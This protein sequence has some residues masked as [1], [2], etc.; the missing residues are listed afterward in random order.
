MVFH[1]R[2]QDWENLLFLQMPNCQQEI[3]RHTEK[4][5]NS[6][7]NKSETVLRKTTQDILDNDHKTA[8]VNMLNELKKNMGKESK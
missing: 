8:V 2:M 1:T 6:Q 5:G 3:I 4:Q 7:Q